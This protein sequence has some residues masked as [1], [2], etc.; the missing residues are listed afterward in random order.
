MKTNVQGLKPLP[1]PREFLLQDAVRCVTPAALRKP[2]IL[3][4]LAVVAVVAACCKATAAWCAIGVLIAFAAAATVCLLWQGSLLCV[5]RKNGVMCPRCRSHLF[6]L[7]CARC[8]A[9]AAPL[10]LLWD[11]RFYRRC[12]H[13][14]GH[15]SSTGGTLLAWCPQCDLCFEQPY[16]WLLKP[17]RRIFWVVE[18]LPGRLDGDWRL[19]EEADTHCVYYRPPD[20]YESVL[21]VV[22]RIKSL[23][24]VRAQ[25]PLAWIDLLVAPTGAPKDDAINLF[26][27]PRAGIASEEALS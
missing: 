26:R 4:A 22:A 9:P 17:M 15:L 23:G 11:G 24:H 8:K 13:C 27:N 19:A 6:Q 18:N 5:V 3:A 14:D 1:A 16:R 12:P 7:V 20:A 2:R 10:A 25:V 21:L